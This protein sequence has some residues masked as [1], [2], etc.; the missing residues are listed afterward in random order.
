MV[1]FKALAAMMAILP[2]A[3]AHPGEN[4]EAIKREMAMRNI[5]HA[6]ASRSLGNCQ[7]SLEAVALR[8]R[9]ATRRAAKAM[10]LR[11]KRGLSKSVSLN[12]PKNKSAEI[13]YAD[14]L[15]QDHSPTEREISPNWRNGPRRV[16]TN[17]R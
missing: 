4:V 13:A 10:E 5:Q 8:K 2:I 7:G 14:S 16:T 11:T 1:G 9:T 15:S 6:V 17:H 3:L 12:V